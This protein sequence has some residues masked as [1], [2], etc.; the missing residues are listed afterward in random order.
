LHHCIVCSWDIPGGN[1]NFATHEASKAHSKK[2]AASTCKKP[3]P[4]MNFFGLS[5]LIPSAL[6]AGPQPTP[7]LSATTFSI[8]II[9]VDAL[10]PTPPV[11]PMMAHLRACTASLLLLV[12]IGT[13]TEPLACFAT[14]PQSLLLLGQ[15]IWEDVIN[16]TYNCILGFGRTIAEILGIIR[17][18]K[19]GMDG[20]YSWTK[21][22][23]K[24]LGITPTL[25]EM[26]LDHL[27]QAMIN[28]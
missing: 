23:I 4:I 14:H 24:E 11:H 18:G 9:D 13:N 3:T 12:P 25:L 10:S 7:A 28:V 5:P 27:M 17:Q 26:H 22:C 19:F 16:P 20:V 15:D 21:S 1:A 8:D 6:H 2:L